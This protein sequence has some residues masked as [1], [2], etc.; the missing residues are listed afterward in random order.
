MFVFNFST[1][2]N[3]FKRHLT[4]KNFYL[5]FIFT[6]GLGVCGRRTGLFI[7]YIIAP[8]FILAGSLFFAIIFLCKL[9]TNNYKLAISFTGTLFVTLEGISRIKQH[10]YQ[11]RL[12]FNDFYV[13]FDPSNFDVLL[14]YPE[15][16][17]A[18]AGLFI[19]L[20]FNIYLY[21]ECN[22]FKTFN[23]KNSVISVI[24]CLSCLG[25]L[26][27]TL[28]Q[29]KKELTFVWLNSMP[30]GKGTISNLILSAGNLE[31]SPPSF[32]MNANYFIEQ[33]K[34]IELNIPQ[35][36]SKPDVVI[37][38][39]E[40]TFNPHF[41]K[42]PTEH[43]IPKF[44]MFDKGIHGLL[45]VQTYGGATWISE[46]NILSGLNP[47]DFGASKQAV[48]YSIAPHTKYSLF[49][50]FINNGYEVLVLSPFTYGNYNAGATYT[51]FGMTQFVSPQDL[52]YPAPSYKKI[53]DIST[54]KLLDYTKILLQQKK[55][56]PRLIYVTSI[57]EHGKYNKLKQNKYNIGNF[58]DEG[59]A[60]KQLFQ[61]NDYVDRIEK[62]NSAT[63][64]FIEHIKKRDDK[65]LFFYFGD[66]QP[67]I[68]H[69]KDFGRNI[70]EPSYITNYSLVTNYSDTSKE[71]ELT[72]LTLASGLIV[73]QAGIYPDEFYEANIKMGYLCHLKLDD[74]E[75]K[76]LTNSFK[77]YIYDHLKAAG[78][79]SLF[80]SN[81]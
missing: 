36:D 23:I 52:G 44:E 66:H 61:I 80:K 6:C 74:C 45:R 71:I 68:W 65:T 9:L 79:P 53:W 54:A 60:Q 29:H 13:M 57:A 16:L 18:I 69:P 26:F 40:S 43:N 76:N 15:S 2:K 72:D 8:Y 33:A 34:N 17:L 42:L 39:Q 30:W 12:M 67:A 35:L 20:S 51:H 11:E 3:Q 24:L 7:E 31:Y 73:E 48:F 28:K 64:D 21:F 22:K 56:K 1:I 37:L 46:F 58:A 4:G 63:L 49:K 5:L 14:Q 55:D 25:I 62:L 27:T 59:F 19:W 50:Q 78:E 75:D 77:N 10:Y 47:S 32:P 38:L 41:Y 81:W 70:N